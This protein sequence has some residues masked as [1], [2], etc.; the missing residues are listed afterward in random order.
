MFPGAREHQEVVLSH[1]VLLCDALEVNGLQVIFVQVFPVA[2][3]NA[4]LSGQR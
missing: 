1:N 2:V 4:H 3:G